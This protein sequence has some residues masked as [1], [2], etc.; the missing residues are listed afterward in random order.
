MHE[1]NNLVHDGLNNHQ[2]HH[3]KRKKENC[4]VDMQKDDK[5]LP[6]LR[7][8]LALSSGM[9]T[10]VPIIL[11]LGHMLIFLYLWGDMTHHVDQQ[12]CTCSCWDTVFKGKLNIESDG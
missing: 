9:A 1:S 10:L 12:H 3:Q 11:P 8:H 2:Q 5:I 6:G 4:A 7:K